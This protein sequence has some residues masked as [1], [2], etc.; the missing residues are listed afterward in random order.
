MVR[1]ECYKSIKDVPDMVWKQ[2]S[3]LDAVGLEINHLRAVETSSINNIQP[4]YLIGYCKEIPVGIAYCFSLQVNFGQMA[5]NCPANVFAAI[6]TWKPDFMDVRMIEVGHIASLG[7][8]IKTLPE[9]TAGFLA[10]LSNKINEIARQENADICLIR[11]IDHLNFPAFKILEDFG[12][13]PVMGFPIACLPIK[14]DNLNSYLASLKAKKRSNILFRRLKIAVPEIS[15]EIIEDYAP[16]AEKLTELWT[17]VAKHNN[18]YEH[19]QLTPDY[20][21]AMSLHM[22]GRSHVVAIKR[23]D[24]IIAYGLNLIGDRE[25]FGMAEGMDYSFRDQYDLYANNIF[26]SLNVACNLGK[27]MFNIGIRLTI[28][29]HFLEWS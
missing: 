22:K 3:P 23:H 14:W 7:S 21:R 26:E 5:K 17:N 24:I 25:Y 6:K 15:V 12:Y 2:F 4:Y 28:L 20:F 27:K 29:K 13:C 10:S 16:Y 11:D 18:G 19:E 1:L 8:T 9:Y